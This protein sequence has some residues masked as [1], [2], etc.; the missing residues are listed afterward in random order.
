MTFKEYMTDEFL[1][2]KDDEGEMSI[3][4]NTLS[5]SLF[6]KSL[7][8]TN[9]GV[10]FFCSLFNCFQRLKSL[11]EDDYT[12][13]L[14]SHSITIYGLR[15]LAKYGLIEIQSCK[16]TDTGNLTNYY[17]SIGNIKSRTSI[18]LYN[19]KFKKRR[20]IK[21]DDEDLIWK[22]GSALHVR[23]EDLVFQ[24]R[25]GILE[26]HLNPKI[27]IRNIATGKAFKRFIAQYRA[28]FG[29]G[30]VLSDMISITIDV[31]SPK[32]KQKRH[33]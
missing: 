21:D 24:N 11:D 27:T 6:F 19:M 23:R 31:T 9:S 8:Y 13:N 16:Q 15:M 32:L 33:R 10:L 17:K 26:A 14:N 29:K 18:K 22:I 28:I 30:G 20:S 25:D 1:V 5:L 2:T 7:V 3:T 12:Y 4:Q